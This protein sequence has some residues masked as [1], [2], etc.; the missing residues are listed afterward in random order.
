MKYKNSDKFGEK[1][2]FQSSGREKGEFKKKD[3][4]EFQSSG[5]EKRYPIVA[6]SINVAI[7]I[8]KNITIMFAFQ[9]KVEFAKLDFQKESN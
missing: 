7:G 3:R 2:K 8:K 5:K 4:K 9:P 1:G 6:F